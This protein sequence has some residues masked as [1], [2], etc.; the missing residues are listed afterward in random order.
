MKATHL[1]TKSAAGRLLILIVAAA[2]TAQAQDRPAI[3]SALVANQKAFQ[4]YSWKSTLVS[5]A[6]GATESTDVYTV[7]RDNAGKLS[8]TRVSTQERGFANRGQEK[9]SR[10]YRSRIQSLTLSYL[11]ALDPDKLSKALT[12]APIEPYTGA[13][14]KITLKGVRQKGDVVMLFV[15]QK[16]SLP[17][18]ADIQTKAGSDN[19]TMQAT[20]TTMPGRAG[21]VAPAKVVVNVPGEKRLLTMANSDFAVKTPT[22]ASTANP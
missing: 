18:R 1:W 9:R 17:V 13:T 6:N 14:Y 21:Y 11:G 19:V 8:S 20:F 15:D 7:S 10:D 16:N 12:T 22:S 3:T 5:T 4:G 2:G